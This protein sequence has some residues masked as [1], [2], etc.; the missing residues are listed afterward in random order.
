MI[1]EVPP[2]LGTRVGSAFTSTVPTA[3]APIGVERLAAA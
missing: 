1:W 2:V 3:A